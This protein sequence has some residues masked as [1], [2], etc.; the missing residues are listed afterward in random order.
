MF[1]G[2]HGIAVHGM[3]EN[4]ASSRGR[5][6]SH[7]FSRVAVET[8]GTFSGYSGD[9]HSEFVF[10]QQH[11]DSCVVTRENSGISTRLGNAIGMVLEVRLQTE[12]PFLFAT[13]LLRFLSISR[14][15]RH[16]HLLKH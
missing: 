5:G 15:V 12:R 16:R 14:I 13:V 7:I 11:L 1:D 2:E 9:G 4:R 10:V 3:Q 6:E 8:W